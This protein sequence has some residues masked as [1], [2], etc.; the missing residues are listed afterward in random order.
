MIEIE[1]LHKRF[2]QKI[3]LDGV[4][5]NIPE[6]DSICIIG[7]SG[8]G[9]SVMLKHIVGL[10]EPDEGLVKVDGQRIDKLNKKQIFELR[11][12]MGFVFQ[13]AALFDSMNV[14]ENSILGMYEHGVKDEKQLEKEAIRVLSAVQLLPEINDVGENVFNKEWQILKYK[15]PS[16]LSGGMRKRVGVARAL[17]GMPKYIFYDEPTTGLDPVT[18]EQIDDLIAELSMRMKVTSVVITH[19]IFSVF[20][21]AKTVAMLHEGKLRYFGDVLG[22]RNSQD[23]I[24]QEFIDRFVRN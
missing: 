12:Q 6:G 23:E 8:S 4:S 16:D 2:G 5:F 13:G 9:K 10:L 7:K 18:S 19:D 24:V 14:F 3:V 20:R 1:N 17:V 15:K 21:I 22:L 11:R